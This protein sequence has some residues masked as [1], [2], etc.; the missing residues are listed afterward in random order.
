[1]FRIFLIV[2]TVAFLILPF[3]SL[4]QEVI[5]F[6]ELA[7]DQ[8]LGDRDGEG[9]LM[10]GFLKLQNDD[11]WYSLVH[12]TDGIL[13]GIYKTYDPAGNLI[14]ESEYFFGQKIYSKKYTE[15]GDIDSRI[16]FYRFT[17][18]EGKQSKSD[19]YLNGKFRLDVVKTTTPYYS[20]K[21]KEYI[22]YEVK[23]GKLLSGEEIA[24]YKS[25]KMLTRYK[26][27]GGK[28]K[29]L[30][31]FIREGKLLKTFPHVQSYDLSE[32]SRE[33]H[34]AFDYKVTEVGQNIYRWD[35]K[36]GNPLDGKYKFYTFSDDQISSLKTFKNGFEHGINYEFNK[37]G[38]LKKER[39]YQ[40]GKLNGILY[41]NDGIRVEVVSFMD[42]VTHGLNLNFN[43]DAGVM[44]DSVNYSYGKK[45]G[46]EVKRYLDTNHSVER[47]N[48]KNGEIHGKVETIA[49]D[50][51]GESYLKK[52]EYYQFGKKTGTHIEYDS[53][54]NVVLT[55]NNYKFD[56]L[57]GPQMRRVGNRRYEEVYQLG[58][59][60]SSSV[61][62]N[63]IL[64]SEWYLEGN[65]ALSM[66][67]DEKGNLK[68]EYFAYADD[69]E[70]QK[71]DSLIMKYYSSEG[72]LTK[73]RVVVI[74]EPTKYASIDNKYWEY[75]YETKR[76]PITTF[77]TEEYPSKKI[78]VYEGNI[79]IKVINQPS[80]PTDGDERMI[81]YLT[82]S[83]KVQ[84]QCKSV[85]H[86]QS[87]KEGNWNKESC[88]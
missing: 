35:D 53:T 20:E 22:I 10:Q 45:V 46:I 86:K 50:R 85:F 26:L 7:I 61:Y 51:Y 21:G 82:P 43:Y 4:S 23:G 42:G 1:M 59:M 83:G 3:F 29:K 18:L 72:V 48:Y 66:E 24:L 77:V 15:S 78:E 81:Q 44:I 40:E 60:T 75:H 54:G 27:S 68:S 11:G 16:D 57:H 62:E 71:G 80:Y 47:I 33:F 70:M 76:E 19:Q 28:K 38:I 73:E 41:D 25:G 30:E 79:I 39:V 32:Y 84:K 31:V 14:Y 52:E 88:D 36:E 64:R 49:H 67:Y 8:N 12:Y 9:H 55:E 6:K 69:Y 65:R 63:S 13:N 58:N 56:Q 37:D 17:I 34:S 5:N 2:T 87:S 74:N